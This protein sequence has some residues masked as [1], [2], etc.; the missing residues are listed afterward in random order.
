[1]LQKKSKFCKKNLL[2]HARPL[3]K[4]EQEYGRMTTSLVIS[5]FAKQITIFIFLILLLK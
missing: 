1:V 5:V 3:L 4:Q 2:E